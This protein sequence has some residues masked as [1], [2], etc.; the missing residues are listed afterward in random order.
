MVFSIERSNVNERMQYV[1]SFLSFIKTQESVATPPVDSDIVK[2]LR[3]LFFVHLYAAFEKSINEGLEQYLQNIGSL[4]LKFS[5]IASGFLP[6]AL[7]SKFTSL[8]S[9]DRWQSRIDFSVQLDSQE[10]CP[11]NNTVFSM[12]L[13]NTKS[14]IIENIASYIGAANSYTCDDR[15]AR[16]LDEVVEKRNQ[17]AH[18][19]NTPITIGGSGR[20]TDLEVR[21]DATNRILE[22]FFAMLE[23]NFNALDFIKPERKTDYQI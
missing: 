7:D 10:I 2:T 9:G 6:T 3:G 21:I 12:Q 18:G 5:D 1:R 17:V 4:Q 14:K 15:D 23:V 13:Q 19:R 16:Y 8:Q 11:I 22:N 20:A